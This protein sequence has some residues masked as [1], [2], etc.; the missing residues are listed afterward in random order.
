M[1][2]PGSIPT[3]DAA[4][5]VNGFAGSLTNAGKAKIKGLELEL[6]S[7]VTDALNISAMYSFIDAKYDEW[8]VASGASLINVAPY[9]EFQNTP[10]HSANLSATYDWPL[11]MMGRSGTLSLLSSVSYK[12]QV[13]Q[14]EFA[15][16]RRQRRA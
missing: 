16:A 9:A 5:N 15:R 4:G 1:Q 10:K 14:T 8:M 3:F 13:Y 12:S 6:V 7:H 11:A 2:I